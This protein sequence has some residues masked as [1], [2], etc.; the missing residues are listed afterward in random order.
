M[1]FLYLSAG[2]VLGFIVSYLLLKSKLLKQQSESELEKQASEQKLIQE[3][4]ELEKDKSLF[5]DRNQSLAKEREELLSQIQQ[6]RNENTTQSQRLV[7]AEVEF[8]NL[9]E[10]LETQKKEMESLQQKFPSN[11]KY[12]SKILKQNTV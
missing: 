4:F 3:K 11:S 9:R 2:I 7:R 10:K 8:S 12:C 6:L 5:E 1:E